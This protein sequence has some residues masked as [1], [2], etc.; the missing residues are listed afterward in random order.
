CLRGQDLKTSRFQRSSRF[1]AWSALNRT[2][3][4]KPSARARPRA[5]TRPR[6]DIANCG[7][8]RDV[9][10][11]IG[12]RLED[13]AMRRHAAA[14]RSAGPRPNRATARAAIRPTEYQIPSSVVR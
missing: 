13:L 4:I 6:A 8:R 1:G 12:E 2:E 14:F 3:K 9:L 5:S 7:Y 11:R 10:A